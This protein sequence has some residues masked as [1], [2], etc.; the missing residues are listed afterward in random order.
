LAGFEIF[1]REGKKWAERSL[2]FKRFPSWKYLSWYPFLK[3]SH[4]KSSTEHQLFSWSSVGCTEDQLFA[5]F[6]A[7]QKKIARGLVLL[8]YHLEEMSP[9]T[10]EKLGNPKPTTSLAPREMSAL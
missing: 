4:G 1:L 7:K 5:I 2:G 10:A 9:H 8:S 3:I 6:G